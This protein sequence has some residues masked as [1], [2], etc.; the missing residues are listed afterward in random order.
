MIKALCFYIFLTFSLFSIA[1]KIED[2]RWVNVSYKNCLQIHL[3]CDCY[4]INPPVVIAYNSSNTKFIV[5]N[6]GYVIK[7][8]SKGD[9][10]KFNLIDRTAF[11][12]G[13][14]TNVEGN[15]K[16][17]G[18]NMIINDLIEYQKSDSSWL[19]L[20]N[21]SCLGYLNFVL[22][23]NGHGDL[24]HILKTDTLTCT[25]DVQFGINIV[26][27]GKHLWVFEKEN[28]EIKMY[29]WYYPKKHGHKA[30]KI[31]KNRFIIQ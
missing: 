8:Y 11:V 2:E 30:R 16:I 21:D 9:T 23:S 13:D 28:K 22:T 10:I 5:I 15:V 17:I 4:S 6:K 12:K 1:Q 29:R 7:D 19:N 25:C 18:D 3:P 31:L 27:D 26:Y 24:Y 14:S 20:E